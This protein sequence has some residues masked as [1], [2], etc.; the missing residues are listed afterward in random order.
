MERLKCTNCGLVNTVS[1]DKCRRC[2]S[3]LVEVNL[4]QPRPSSSFSLTIPVRP[5][6]FL[7]L[8]LV[9]AYWYFGG[10]SAD[11]RVSTT[12]ERPT[13][14]QPYPTLSVRRE[15]EQ[16]AKGAYF[17]AIEKSPGIR[18]SDKRLEQTNKLI[19]NGRPSPDR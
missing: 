15:Q 5:I 2:Y 4:F 6:L 7:I 18:E 19:E 13:A 12:S 3:P 17:D 1:D 16:K 8:A 14:P 10:T 11:D 9:A